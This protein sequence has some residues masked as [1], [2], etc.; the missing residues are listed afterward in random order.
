MNYYEH[1]IGDFDSAT[2]HLSL[3]EDAVYRRLICLYYRTEAPIPADVKQACRL[4]RAS[5]KQERDTV[6]SVLGE[7]FQLEEDGWHNGRCDQEIE[8]FKAGEPERE[9]RKANE[10]NRLK[11]HREER[12]ELFRRLTDAGQHASWNVSIADLRSLVQRHCQPLPETAPATPATATQ[13]PDTRHQTP[14]EE[15]NQLSLVPARPMA[16]QPPLLVGI[17][18]PKTPPDCPHLAVLALWAEVLPAM[19][20][21]LPSQWRGTRA[22]HLRARWRETA[23]EKRWATQ[24]QGLAY[25][26]KLFAYVG[27]SDFLAGRAPSRDGRR[28]FVIELEWLVNPTNWAKVHEGKYHGDAAA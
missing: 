16:E 17:E 13:T 14:E 5:T 26:R 18:N 15:Y 25:L 28:P 2:A 9:V 7:F 24:E 12:A 21:H 19:P 22:D 10:T 1:H 4:V 27:Q 3:L 20:Q 8:R 11:R 23:V 6:A